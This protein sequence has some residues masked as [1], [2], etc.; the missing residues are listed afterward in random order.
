ML[1]KLGIHRWDI[2]HDQNWYM[3]NYRPGAVRCY[4][5]CRACDYI[6][7]GTYYS[8]P[9]EHYVW[10]KDRDKTLEAILWMLILIP[11]FLMAALFLILRFIT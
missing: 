5:K 8:Q 6:E 1:C 9:F 3:I 4:R 2:V 7:S 11:A 10:D